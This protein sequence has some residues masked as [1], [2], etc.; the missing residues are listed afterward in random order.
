[1]WSALAF[2]IIF[3]DLKKSSVAKA[4]AG[5]AVNAGEYK[6]RQD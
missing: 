3:P 5:T 6:E 4:K 1:M 2:P